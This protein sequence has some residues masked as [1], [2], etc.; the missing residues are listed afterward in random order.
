[1]LKKLIHYEWK[2]VRWIYTALILVYLA[3]F[4]VCMI[5][6]RFPNTFGLACALIFGGL[7]ALGVLMLYI[8]FKRYTA[9]LYGRE[10]YLMFT[11]PVRSEELLLSKLLVAFIGIT[12]YLLV[13]AAVIFLTALCI[14]KG[15]TFRRF[16][17]IQELELFWGKEWPNILQ[18]FFYYIVGLAGVILDLYLA[19][20]ISKLPFWHRF[21]GLMGVL[22]FGALCALKSLPIWLV[23]LIFHVS[24]SGDWFSLYYQKGKTAMSI[25]ISSGFWLML[26]YTAAF[27]V[28]V[29]F[30]TAWIMR[31]HTTLK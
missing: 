8:F 1:M 25:S 14:S 22:A 18:V 15:V 2:A 26:L 31:K 30:F 4:G 5:L 28:G 7:F 17:T 21:Y 24:T 29:F 23:G 16:P 27:A 3:V 19:I 11:L 6:I 9:N 13:A 20:T 12:L 10:G